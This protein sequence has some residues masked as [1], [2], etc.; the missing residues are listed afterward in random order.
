MT[1]INLTTKI[2][3]IE[4]SFDKFNFNNYSGISK[5]QQA[6]YILTKKYFCYNNTLEKFNTTS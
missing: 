1:N 6:V 3:N 4:Q 2:L 5:E